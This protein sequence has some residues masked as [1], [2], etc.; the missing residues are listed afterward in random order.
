M[1]DDSA[2]GTAGQIDDLLVRRDDAHSAEKRA[3]DRQHP[4]GKLTARERIALLVDPDS[5]VEIDEFARHQCVDFGMAANRPAGDSGIAGYATVDGRQICLYSQ[6]FT[7]FGGSMGETFARKVLK[8]MDMALKI[9]CPI[10]C[11]NDSGGARIQEGV[12]SLAAYA[13]IGLRHI[14]ASGVVPQLSLVLGPCAGGA[15][16]GPALTDFTVMADGT[17]H[18][19]ITG[20]EVVSAVTGQHATLDELGGALTNTA[21]SGNAHYLA[22]DEPDAIDW[23]KTLLSYLPSNNT[24]GP[25]SYVDDTADEITARDLELNG[26]IPDQENQT[27]DMFEV[28]RRIVDDGD[29]LEVHDRFAPNMIC[30]FGRVAGQ[31][32]GIVANQPLYH[33]GAIDID[34]S[35]KAARFVRFCDAFNIPL[36]TI[37]DVPGYLPGVEQERGGIIRRGAK[38]LY[39]YGEA[40]VPKI[41]VITRKAFGGGY[42]VMG[43]K[44][45]GADLNL[46]WPTAQIAVMGAAGAVPLLHGRELAGLPEPERSARRQELAAQYR[47]SF[48]TPYVAAERG[49]IDMVLPPAETRAQVTRALRLLRDKREQMPA[50]KHGNVPL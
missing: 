20:P 8:I 13:E 33:A 24:A 4:K 18:M 19:L 6:D 32:V 22:G 7:V 29:L 49:Y 17:S 11:I 44:H 27:Y 45:L 43:S 40:T 1:F 37:A 9:G 12:V 36:L 42:A 10:I 34:A 28:I 5:F 31:S 39:A 3:A 50:R 14:R 46:A 23:I 38:L 30:A 35:E 2:S 21:V 15:A 41:T 47:D 26:I 25:P 48:A 16:Y